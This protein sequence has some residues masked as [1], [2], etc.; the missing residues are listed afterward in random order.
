VSTISPVIASSRLNI[1]PRHSQGFR[2]S[3]D[4]GSTVLAQDLYRRFVSEEE[5]HSRQALAP[6]FAALNQ[7]DATT[8]FVGQCTILTMS[9]EQATGESYCLAHHVTVDH[10]KR[11]FFAPVPRHV[12]KNGRH[13][14]VFGALSLRGLDRRT[15]TVMTPIAPNEAELWRTPALQYGGAVKPA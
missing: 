9:A 15:S 1:L 6:V 3:T 13:L 2:R 12:R 11:R 7:Y 10:G 14:A 5:L 4:S 8:H